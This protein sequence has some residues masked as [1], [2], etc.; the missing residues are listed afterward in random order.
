MT[1][2]VPTT[3]GLSRRDDRAVARAVRGLETA[4]EIG[5]ARLEQ[6]AQVEATKA[7]AVNYV[8]QQAMQAVALTSQLEAQLGQ[9]CPM[10]V[11]RLQGIADITALAVSDV[12]MNSARK[13]SR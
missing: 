6:G 2:I 10:A 11:T 3:G 5:L 9:A 1:N 13:L 8:G 7:H 4:T 12:V